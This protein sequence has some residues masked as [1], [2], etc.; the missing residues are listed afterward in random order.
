MS[1]AKS[2][3]NTSPEWTPQPWQGV[4]SGIVLELGTRQSLTSSTP[5]FGPL[6]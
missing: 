6:S 5:F 4:V 3:P 1:R 2:L